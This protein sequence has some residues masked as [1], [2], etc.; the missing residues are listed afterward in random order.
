[1]QVFKRE[2]RELRREWI[3]KWNG[4]FE[5]MKTRNS[6]KQEETKEHSNYRK[7]KKG[8]ITEELKI[9]G[10]SQWFEGVNIYQL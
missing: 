3:E 5:W 2:R 4:K 6:K 7:E 9:R 1:M 10:K 8:S